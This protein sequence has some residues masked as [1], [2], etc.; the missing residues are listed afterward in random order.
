MQFPGPENTSGA[1]S[2][3]AGLG[4]VQPSLEFLESFKFLPI[5]ML[6]WFGPGPRRHE[7]T[8]TMDQKVAASTPEAAKVA[9]RGR[10][11]FE[12]SLLW[13]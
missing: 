12:V 2:R 5:G 3:K 9:T 1:V 4:M 8:R 11:F 13:T 7:P 10:R 6:G